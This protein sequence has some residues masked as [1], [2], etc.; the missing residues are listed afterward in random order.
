MRFL[1]EYVVRD[2]DRTPR[3]RVRVFDE[4]QHAWNAEYGKKK[5]GRPDSEPTL[6][7]QIMG[8]HDGWAVIVALVG[9]GQEI[10]RGEGGL[11]EWGRALATI[12]AQ[13][14]GWRIPRLHRFLVV[15]AP[16]FPAE[17]LELDRLGVKPMNDQ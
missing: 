13:A 1:E 10:N 16:I 12:N 14:C 9:G 15:L 8:R 3:D 7:L 2:K 4:A 6:F 17:I 11:D 5:F